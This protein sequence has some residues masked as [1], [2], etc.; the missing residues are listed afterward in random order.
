MSLNL[1][2]IVEGPHPDGF[3]WIS[4]NEKGALS[5]SPGILQSISFTCLFRSWKKE[6]N[7]LKSDLNQKPNTLILN[8]D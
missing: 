2:S 5:L 3:T 4:G 1:V 7:Q 8:K 6:A